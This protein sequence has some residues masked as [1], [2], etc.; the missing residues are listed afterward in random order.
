ML[1]FLAFIHLSVYAL[2]QTSVKDQMV[3]HSN[4][5]DFKLIWE[6]P[7]LHA[8]LVILLAITS[9]I[10]KFLKRQPDRLVGR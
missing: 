3:A 4:E 9:I 8:N 10:K 7:E 1:H 2:L 5:R 6:G